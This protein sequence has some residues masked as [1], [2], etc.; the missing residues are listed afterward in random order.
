ME[1]RRTFNAS[2]LSLRAFAPSVSSG[3]C[4]HCIIATPLLESGVSQCLKIALCWCE[5]SSSRCLV[6]LPFAPVHT[7][8]PTRGPSTVREQAQCTCKLLELV[9]TPF[10]LSCCSLSHLTTWV[11]LPAPRQMPAELSF[12][13][14]RCGEVTETQQFGFVFELVLEKQNNA[15]QCIFIFL[16]W[17]C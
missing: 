15:N 8:T 13:W 14:H 5:I 16:S 17:A 4:K 2:V 6:F 12:S 3:G 10:V 1:K 11:L 9:N 7:L